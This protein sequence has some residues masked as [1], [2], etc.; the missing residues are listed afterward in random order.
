MYLTT[1][2]HKKGNQIC[3]KKIGRGK[4]NNEKLANWAAIFYAKLVTN[5][6]FDLAMRASS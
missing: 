2:C 3:Q 5:L 1:V 6:P 4:K